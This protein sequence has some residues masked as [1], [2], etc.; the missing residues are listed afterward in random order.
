MSDAD[1]PLDD[2]RDALADIQILARFALQGGDTARM[3]RDL[4]MILIITEMV[5]PP[6]R[7]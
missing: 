4:E 7:K 2:P 5:L 1:R 3:K 6:R